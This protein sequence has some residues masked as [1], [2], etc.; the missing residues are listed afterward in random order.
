MIEDEITDLQEE[1]AALA[2]I[3][4]A[5]ADRPASVPPAQ[6]PAILL[7]AGP[8]ALT[9][10]ARSVTGE[11]QAIEGLVMISGPAEG[12]ALDQAYD[13]ARTV[14]GELVTLYKELISGPASLESSEAVVIGYTDP[15]DPG[16]LVEYEG[17]Q[18]IGFTFT[19]QLWRP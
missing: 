9:P 3:V 17:Q 18:Y 8:Y 4:Y 19:V 11:T 5:P 13:L 15:G 16:Q 1:H 7:R 10:A 6:C 2:S 12:I 14:R